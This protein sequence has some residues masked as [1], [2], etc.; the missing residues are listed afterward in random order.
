MS[1]EEA[2]KAKVEALRG[3]HLALQAFLDPLEPYFAFFPRFQE[4]LYRQFAEA[5]ESL[6]RSLVSLQSEGILPGLDPENFE[7]L[8]VLWSSELYRVYLEAIGFSPPEDVR[9]SAHLG[10][11]VKDLSAFRERCQGVEGCYGLI[12]HWESVLQ[13]SCPELYLLPFL[14][15]GQTEGCDLA[16][17]WGRGTHTVLARSPA[18]R[19]KSYDYS[20]ERL[21]QLYSLAK[22]EGWNDRVETQACRITELPLAADSIDFMVAADIFELLPE[23]ILLKTLDEI[24]RVCRPGAILYFKVTLNAYQPVLGQVQN[25]S[26]RKVK[27]LFEGRMSEGKSMVLCFH[28]LMAAEH[29]TFQVRNE[30]TPPR[31]LSLSSAVHSPARSRGARLRKLRRS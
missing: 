22:A 18:L 7:H 21:R 3:Q 12:D 15:P 28:D 1:L 25:F 19:V 5:G 14:S 6:G 16:C 8:I 27:E 30:A 9:L 23:T 20:P 17:G 13:K 2:E 11:P 4:R 31:V 24:L 26:P 10:P 29:F